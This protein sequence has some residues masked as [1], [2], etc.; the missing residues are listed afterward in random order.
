MIETEIIF[1]DWAPINSKS[2][3]RSGGHIRRYYAWIT[4]NKMV[5]SVLPFREKSGNINWKAVCHMFK[6]DSALWVEY[7]CGGVAHL[8][9]LFA[10]FI[11]SKKLIISVHDLAIQQK[12]VDKS[13][14]FLK[15][16]R[17]QIIERL[18]LNRASTIILA[19]PELLNYF[20]PEKNQKVLIMPPGVGEDELFMHPSDKIDKRKKIALYFGSM[21]R[22]DMIP[23]SIELFSELKGWELHLIGLEEGGEIVEN[24][25]V[26]YLG[27]VG[28]DKL[29]DVLINVDVIII[30]YPKNDYLDKAMPIKLGYALKSCRPVIATKLRGVS[31]YIS[32]VGLEENVIYVEEWNL[33]S[34]KEA[35]EK[36][37]SL[38]IDAEKT[39][40]RLRPMA[41]EPRFE[42][43]VKIALDTS[44]ATRDSI[45][46]I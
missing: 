15:R 34:L 38:N 29:V 41:W 20:T 3:I 25:N 31:E 4:L 27:S 46:W 8:F 28:H 33:D 17:L 16:I 45:E 19:C 21:R 22:K 10:S 35:L 12:Y 30:P 23:M 18:L 24:K 11:R 13:P 26:R 42:K 40:E 43:A 44:Q 36:A 2:D 6:K 7:G 14:A 32:M 37:Q 39:I 5:D 1:V 9:V